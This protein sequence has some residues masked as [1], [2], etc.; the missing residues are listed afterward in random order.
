MSKTWKTCSYDWARLLC[1][2]WAFTIASGCCWGANWCCEG[3]KIATWI[4]LFKRS[5]DLILIM[6]KFNLHNIDYV[7]FLCKPCQLTFF[8]CHRAWLLP[9]QR[10]IPFLACQEF[11]PSPPSNPSL[12]KHSKAMAR[13][14]STILSP[15]IQTKHHK[16]SSS[17]WGWSSII[18]SFELK[19]F[20]QAFNICSIFCNLFLLGSCFH[21]SF[22]VIHLIILSKNSYE[23]HMN[24]AHIINTNEIWTL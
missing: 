2:C 20:L 15:N 22:Q 3:K 18:G 13:Y 21:I 10:T 7:L 24:H 11:F 6:S 14:F 4:L 17:I 5:Q 8:I 12:P 16:Y 19:H 1:L 23:L 9:R